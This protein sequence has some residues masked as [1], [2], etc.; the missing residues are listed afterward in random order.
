MGKKMTADLS[1]LFVAFI[2]G[3]TFVLV[4]NAIAFL[5]PLAFNAIR[6]FMAAVVLLILLIFLH[7]RNRI[8]IHK[9]LLLSGF[10]LGIWLF[11]GYGF[12]TVG[13]L[14]TTSSKAGF[15]TG[16]SVVL[17]PIIC[18]IWLRQKIRPQ[19]SLGVII[20]TVG[21]YFLTLLDYSTLNVGDFFVLLCAFSFAGHIV[22]TSKYAKDHS[23]LILTTIQILTVSILSLIASLI[24]EKPWTINYSVV[25]KVEV[26]L[27]LLICAL[28][29]TAL[30]FFI[31]THFQQH[32]SP[33]R[34]ALIFAMEPVF[35]A[36]TAY[37]WADERLSLMAI[38][39]CVFIFLGM[40]LA[41]L[42]IRKRIEKIETF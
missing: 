11:L 13:L 20:A 4:Q 7:K 5:P 2:W 8:V 34:V 27:A 29:A 23:P 22:L 37:F 9:K 31:Q 17:V 10:L 42:P 24:F 15:I 28:L 40:I 1:L 21:L 19:A 18:F 41:E 16:L 6:F 35:A 12:Q 3:A 25:L 26:V 32:T 14:F 38:T 36:T 39:G 30:A 33:T